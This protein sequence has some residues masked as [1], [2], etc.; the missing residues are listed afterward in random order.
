MARRDLTFRVFVSSTFS[1]LVA[2]RNALQ[3]HVFPRL[4]DYCH[5]RGARFQ[6]ID[7]RWGVSE[8]AALDQQ[9]MIICL[10]ELKRCQEI[11]PRPN[12][13][14]L[15]GERYGW[16]PLPPRIWAEELER[17]FKIM[18]KKE[19]AAVNKWYWPDDN[20][21][22]REYL[23]QPRTGE[24]KDH[25][26][27][28]EEELQLHGILLR[29]ARSVLQP[30]DE[31]INKYLD[32]ATHQE[33]RHGVLRAENAATHVFSY[34]RTIDNLPQ[35]DRAKDY[36]DI[37]DHTVDVEAHARL[38]ALKAELKAALPNQ[39]VY[40]YSA[41]WR[42]ESPASDLQA[43]CDRLES[44][45]RVVIDEELASP[46]PPASETGDGPTGA[47][48]EQEL[49]ERFLDSMIESGRTHEQ[50]L[51]GAADMIQTIADYL[52]LSAEH[53]LAICA[54]PG[55]GGSALVALA[56]QQARER[57]PVALVIARFV[58][59]T[60]DSTDGK[61]L[62]LNLCAQLGSSTGSGP[63]HIPS[64]EKG[65]F[66]EF[67]RRLRLAAN[68]VPVILF[69]DGLQGLI[70]SR[71]IRT[72]DWLPMDLPAHA[73]IVLSLRPSECLS[74]IKAKL[75]KHN[76]VCLSPE[77]V[78][79][80][81]VAELL[82]YSLS[83]AKRTLQDYQ[84]TN[85]LLTIANSTLTPLYARVFQRFAFEEVK[86]WHSYDGIPE[87][88][89]KAGL[90]SDLRG[91]LSDFLWRLSRTGSHEEVLVRRCLGY[92]ATSRMGLAEDELLEILSRD[93]EVYE[94]FFR[95]T[96]H[97]PPDLVACIRKRLPDLFS[98]VA[99]AHP[100]AANDGAAVASLLDVMR[101]DDTHLR[102][103]LARVLSEPDGPRLPAI[104]WARLHFDLAPYLSWR[105]V[106][107]TRLLDL[108]HREFRSVLL[109][110]YL[111]RAERLEC[112]RR[113]AEWFDHQPPWI[114]H[115]GTRVAN[116]RRMAEL[117]YHQE[118]AAELCE[119]ETPAS[120][121]ARSDSQET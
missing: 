98:D 40:E 5:Q 86:Q 121:S 44:D 116:S 22:P 88:N 37:K 99:R 57:Y 63:P 84:R 90:S 117:K 93:V 50:F 15:L 60:L 73:H 25:E 55:A 78:S 111:S 26:R 76:Q 66:V 85:V 110:H 21:V 100:L 7:L 102:A 94:R 118:K 52:A 53:P 27:W 107:G 62:L 11:S 16:R 59:A 47:L 108:F 51:L 69:L 18:T 106:D 23:L 38:Q 80:N 17:L 61:T 45:L 28:V 48:S 68:R 10:E 115:K 54:E 105:I 24:F 30:N 56:V 42:N 12:F 112:H 19:Q 9:T 82:D 35:D 67:Q 20:S 49:H 3:E 2:E 120:S 58:G 64:E 34:L 83:S 103:F 39:H 1:D 101:R 75:P 74:A 77:S 87:Y 31:A 36:R 72:L 91:I 113:L 89:G 8:E 46:R 14:V 13:I 109:E 81:R 71:A 96:F 104:V 97:P 92:L 41:Q 43:L 65:L 4:R 33:I 114:L 70:G 119:L 32:S 95:S 29:A 79:R 6:A